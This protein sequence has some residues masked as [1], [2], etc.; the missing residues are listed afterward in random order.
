M[1]AAKVLRARE[2]VP[3]HTLDFKSLLKRQLALQ[4]LTVRTFVKLLTLPQIMGAAKDP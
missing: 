3:H 1:N 2:Q 4:K